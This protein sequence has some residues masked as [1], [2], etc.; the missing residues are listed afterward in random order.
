MDVVEKQRLRAIGYEGAELEKA[1]VAGDENPDDAA[2]DNVVA[3]GVAR[4]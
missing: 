3:I 1:V 4:T 2:V